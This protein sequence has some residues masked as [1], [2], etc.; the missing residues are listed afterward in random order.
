MLQL[1]ILSAVGVVA[2]VWL[3]A[4]KYPEALRGLAFYDGAQSVLAVRGL[5]SV[6]RSNCVASSGV[7]A[8]SSGF[9]LV[10]IGVPRLIDII[11]SFL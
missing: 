3:D 9:K 4:L 1:A 8:Y 5:A 2:I 7:M 11:I 6:L 10:L